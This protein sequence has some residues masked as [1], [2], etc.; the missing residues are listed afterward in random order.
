MKL[1]ELIIEYSEQSRAFL[2]RSLADVQTKVYLWFIFWVT[3]VDKRFKVLHGHIKLA[4]L[5]IMI[6]ILRAQ[7]KRIGWCGHL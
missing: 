6:W 1:I 7:E 4:C 3:F 5:K 2:V